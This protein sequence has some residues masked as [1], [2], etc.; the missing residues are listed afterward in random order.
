MKTQ[1]VLQTGTVQSVNYAS[2]TVNVTFTDISDSSENNLQMFG[3]IYKMPEIGDIVACL[4]LDNNP[5][6]GFCLGKPFSEDSPPVV[7]GEGVFY[8]DLFGEGFIQYD[9]SSK[10]LTLHADHIV[11]EQKGSN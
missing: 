9:C 1:A 11:T 6:R 4:F 8:L 5:T 2:G 3:P 10:T 7:F